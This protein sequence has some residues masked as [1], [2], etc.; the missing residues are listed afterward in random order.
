MHYKLNIPIYL[1]P[2]DYL[3]RNHPNFL[4]LQLY[5]LYCRFNHVKIQ[6]KSEQPPKLVYKDHTRQ[7]PYQSHGNSPGPG[8]NH[9]HGAD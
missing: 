1:T 4:M 6:L 8:Y 7:L 5:Y 2:D 9:Q 3:D